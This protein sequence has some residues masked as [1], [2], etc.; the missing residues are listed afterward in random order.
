MTPRVFFYADDFTGGTASLAG[1]HRAGLKARMFL[2]TPDVEAFARHAAAAEVIG[3]AGIARSL[4]P[5][6]MEA[7]V[8]PAFEFFYRAGATF[9][10][11]KICSTFDSSLERGNLVR[12]IEIGQSIFSREATPVVPACP[13]TGRYT[14]F[15]NHFATFSGEV[16]RLDWHPVMS[17]H[18]VTPMH[19]ADLRRHLRK[20]GPVDVGLVDLRDYD[21]GADR[22]MSAFAAAGKTSDA[23]VF[24]ATGF[25]HL[26]A[27]AGM[28]WRRRM[29]A[30][31]FVLAAQDFSEALGLCL[32]GEKRAAAFLPV[33]VAPAD[34]LLVLSG[35]G[36]QLNADQIAHALATGLFS[37]V[38]L[39]LSALE[40]G[41]TPGSTADALT[42]TIG[43][44]FRSAR[45]VIVHSFLGPDDRRLA[46]SASGNSDALLGAAYARLIQRC[47]ERFGV[48]RVVVAGG[49]TSSW[50]MRALDVEA[51]E[52]VTGF[53]GGGNLCRIG[54]AG[55]L[56]GLEV[57]LKGGQV[58]AD[59]LLVKAL[60]EASRASRGPA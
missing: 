17:R 30:P 44:R 2:K 26:Q 37:D 40:A 23:V 41:D 50:T 24:D 46:S 33:E 54:D 39:D 19:E 13:K 49:D 12:I 7:E 36:S 60:G 47:V 5:E 1:F 4:A 14:V 18:P 6:A 15:G 35:S 16:Y 52:I 28:L 48:R 43:H 11:Y 8:R 9:V 55:P 31:V 22:L 3:I 42:E 59:D 38:P 57:V 10:Q 29:D 32:A 21:G 58:G 27:I 34:R 45:G 20:Q 56:D 51:L 25:D 53:A